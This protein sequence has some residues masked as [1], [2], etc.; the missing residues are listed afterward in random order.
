MV[1]FSLILQNALLIEAAEDV[2]DACW[3]AR[4]MRERQALP[5]LERRAVCSLWAR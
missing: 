2:V 4:G 3:Q 5:R 1:A